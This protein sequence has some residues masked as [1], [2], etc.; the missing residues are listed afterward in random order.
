MLQWSVGLGV[1]SEAGGT[2]SWETFMTREFPGAI[3]QDRF[4][5]RSYEALGQHGFRPENT[6]AFASVC[7]DEIT[8]SL[9]EDIER[10]WGEVFVFSSLG[11]ML[12]LGKTGF[13]AAQQHA[14]IENERERYVYYAL[15]HIAIDA[16]GEFGI[17]YRPGRQKASHACGALM[18]FQHELESRSLQLAP[19]PDDI[20]QSVLKR[21]L[22]GKLRYG[23]VPDLPSLTRIAHA[24]ILEELERMI[25][26]TVDPTRSDYGL[27]TGIQIHIPGGRH[28]VWPGAAYAMKNE[29]K[30]SL[31]D[32]K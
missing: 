32:V 24:V 8:L 25:R 30:V 28:F 18:A 7:R 9:V 19:D 12:T 20:E 11:G 26:L 6:I 29:T 10:T 14:P 27:F 4:V 2:M 5:A 13:L 1:Q 16:Q 23:D 3:P 17:Y 21:H 31:S 15:P 22:L